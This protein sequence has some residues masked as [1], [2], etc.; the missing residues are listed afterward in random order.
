[1]NKT[2]LERFILKYSLGGTVDSVKWVFKG[3]K[4]YTSFMTPDKALLGK[5]VVNDVQFQNAV[6]GVYSTNLLSRLLSVVEGNLDMKLFMIDE[7]PIAL[8]ITSGYSEV[9]F[10]LADLSVFPSPPDLKTLPTF[11]TEI[12]IDNNFIN[13]FIR[14]KSALSD[15]DTFTVVYNGSTKIVIGHSKTN[16]HKVTIPVQSN[17]TF[18]SENQTFNANF[19][20]EILAA[21]RESQSAKLRISDKGLAHIVFDSGDYFSEYYLTALRDTD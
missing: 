11:E 3:D 21:N 8:K 1:M 5:V 10:A 9:S 16:S 2:K 4:L 17:K 14:G 6:I 13:T 15:V 20:K 12:D 18:L 7:K 19:F